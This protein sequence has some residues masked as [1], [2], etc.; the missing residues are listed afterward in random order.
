LSASETCEDGNRNNGDGCSAS[1]QPE[2]CGDA[3]KT[4]I[5]EC[6]DG[7]RNDGDGCSALCRAEVCGD[8]IVQAPRESCDDKNT[9]DT[10][11]CR[12]GC[13]TAASLNAL[14]GD[15]QNISHITQ[16]VC[17][18]A[19][20][21]WCKQFN[22]NPVAGMVTGQKADN[23]YSVGCITGVKRVEVNSSL[24][25]N[26]C[27]PGKQQSP[28]CLERARA[29]CRGLGTAGIGFYVGVGANSNMT[30]LACGAGTKTATES[31]PGCNGIA[32]TNPVTVECAKALAAKC[33]S[34]QGGMIQDHPQSNQV[35]YTCVDLTLTGTARLR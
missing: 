25:D 16:T 33:G 12:N 6:D 29:A 17:M 20:T 5:E 10:D 21:N 15:C 13:K 26:K 34:G 32:D 8:G 1:C 18:V 31:V 7:N 27:E 3:K 30:A 4:G 19:V 2:V 9:V 11:L 22:N 35:T 24:L 28:A 23:E 14:N